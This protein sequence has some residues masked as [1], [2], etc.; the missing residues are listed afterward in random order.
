MYKKLKGSFSYRDKAHSS[1][2]HIIS[3]AHYV[4]VFAEFHYKRNTEEEEEEDD[5][6]NEEQEAKKKR[7]E[8]ERERL[9]KEGK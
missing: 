3:E 9:C 1:S 6:E 7:R 8:R 2:L 4:E 5:E